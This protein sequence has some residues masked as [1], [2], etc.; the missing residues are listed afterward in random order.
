MK[1][2]RISQSWGLGRFVFL[3]VFTVLFTGLGLWQV[4]RQYTVI[5]RGYRVDRELSDFRREF[6]TRK[7]LSLLLSA[8]KDPNTLRAVALEELGMTLP[9]RDHELH[10]PGPAHRPSPIPAPVSAD[11]PMPTAPAGPSDLEGAR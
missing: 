10:V 5:E 2:R 9:D 11:D 7:R 4:N 8:H 1:K 6:E 3:I